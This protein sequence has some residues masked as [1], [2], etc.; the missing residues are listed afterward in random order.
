MWHPG[1]HP[2]IPSTPVP[3]DFLEL[4]FN[5]CRFRISG[6]E[7]PEKGTLTLL[8]EFFSASNPVASLDNKIF[9]LIPFVSPWDSPVLIFKK[10]QFLLVLLDPV[11]VEA[12]EGV[13]WTRPRVASWWKL[14]FSR[15]KVTKRHLEAGTVEGSTGIPASE[16]DDSK[17]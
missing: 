15:R 16:G 13:F 5:F 2:V 7:I 12:I 4:P 11:T 17:V 3:L 10:Q 14:K 6:S 1:Q 9:C 8:H